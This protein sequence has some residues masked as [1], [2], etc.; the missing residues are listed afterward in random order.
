[1]LLFLNIPNIV[2]EIRKQNKAYKF[3]ILIIIVFLQLDVSAQ[4]KTLPYSVNTYR[5]INYDSCY[6][7]NFGNN[8]Q[9]EIFFKKL[10]DLC[11]DGTGQI[12]ILHLGGSHIQAGIWSWEL[13]KKFENLCPG[14]EGAPGM[15][16]P[17][18]IASTNHPYYYK[19]SFK[20]KW[21]IAKIT[22]KEPAEKI[23]LAGMTAFTE[24]TVAEIIISFNP[25]ANIDKHKFNKISIF[26]NV[27]DTAYLLSVYPEEFLDSCMENKVVGASEYYF[28]KDLD[29]VKIRVVK[30]DT[31]RSKFYFYGAFLQNSKPG[32][33]Y[34]GIGINGASTHSYLKAEYFKQHLTL[35]NPDLAILSIGVNDASG[36]AFS[37]DNYIK[38]YSKILEMIREVNPDC[39]II[40]TTN[41]DFYYYR[42]GSNMHYNEV[43]SGML[44]LAED[45]GCSVWN[46]FKVM[47]GLKSIN[48]WKKDKLANNDRIH[49][50]RDGYTLIAS[51]FFD[52]ILRDYETYLRKHAVDNEIK[53]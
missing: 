31:S 33:C 32:I 43:Y 23:G 18:S 1:M 49:F 44:K 11:F 20:G 50:T 25:A 15:V 24:D 48:L 2:K 36:P 45:Y 9:M 16:F 22:D 17:F 26:H 35:L 10:D 51:L 42:G 53:D 28:S 14:M 27:E 4:D 41:N 40:F 3:L 39:A 8:H 12:S 5:Y 37:E 52:A 21:D 7:E 38:N 29:S 47:G 19:S 30:Q 6:L 46:M 34:N 13:R